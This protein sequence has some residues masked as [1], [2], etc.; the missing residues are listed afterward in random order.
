[1]AGNVLSN[2]YPPII[3]SYMPAFLRTQGCR[4]YFSISNFNSYNDIRSNAQ[5]TVKNQNSNAS[6]LK[7]SEY[8]NG[9]KICNVIEDTE[10]EDDYKYYI[11]L[12][13]TD[14]EKGFELNQYYKVQI[15]FTDAALSKPDKSIEGQWLA[16]N[17]AYFSE[18]STI[19]LI[20]GISKPTVTI[21][22]FEK[23]SDDI[24][25]AITTN[26]VDF[27][28]SV[29]F[30]DPGEEETLRSYRIKLY[31]EKD[32]LLTDSGDIYSSSYNSI[33]QI[34]YTFEYE[35]V[36]GNSYQIELEI[37]TYNLYTELYRYDFNVI[38]SG[39][40]KL[41]ADISVTPDEEG[42]YNI[43]KLIGKTSDIFT[44]NITIRRTSSKSNFLLWEDIHTEAISEGKPLDYT[45]YDFSIES[46]VWYKYCAQKRNNLGH[47][48]VALQY[49]AAVMCMFE[50]IFLVGDNKQLRI[51]YN[52]QVS[53]YKRTVIDAKTDT[54]G[55][56]FPFIKRN[57]YV[58][59]RQFPISGMIT[60]F[61]DY[62]DIFTSREELFGDKSIELYDAYN[63][64]N[65]I[66]SYNDFVHEREFREKVMDFLYADKV[67]LF[68]SLSEGNILIRLMD[69]NLTPET[70]LGRQIYS[71]SATAC[72]VDTCT[73]KNLDKYYIQSLGDYSHLITYSNHI[74]DK[75]DG[76]FSAGESNDLITVL[77]QKKYNEIVP[78]G[79][80]SVIKYL[81]YL[82]IEFKMPPYLIKEDGGNLRKLEATEEPD[83]TTVLG[84]IA[85]INNI[86][87]LINSEGIYELKG[88]EIK[89]NSLYFPID[90]IATVD[91][92]VLIS[93]T[94][95]T[96]KLAK[97]IY[98][99]QRIGQIGGSF[100]YKD[101]VFQ[102]IWNKYRLEYKAYY[103][104]LISINSVKIEAN[105]GTVVWIK[106]SNNTDLER[107][108]INENNSLQIYDDNSVIEGLYFCG[109]HL[110]PANDL[111]KQGESLPENK[112]IE[113]GI[114][115]IDSSFIENPIQNG[116]YTFSNQPLGLIGEEI[117]TDSAEIEDDEI[118]STT[119]SLYEQLLETIT[120]NATRYIYYKDKWRIFTGDNDVLCSVDAIVDYFCEIMKGVY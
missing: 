23:A 41:D 70:T 35:L 108:V 44:G 7:K 86:P 27:I 118:K 72:E 62:N 83:A 91:Y 15:R 107:Y 5:V 2:L 106:E 117:P 49:P 24:S 92:N 20:K 81:D 29:S 22:N 47:R 37:T 95:D 67:R 55:S 109:Y 111:D 57:G 34:N 77:L 39:S 114:E 82:R 61:D 85:Y 46:G 89:V 54:I 99:T 60:L 31:N 4:I 93:E 56:Q 65:R 110:E 40:D 50:D 25:I 98:Y 12:D 36:D 119:D 103:Q 42:G 28:G 3:E 51:K 38:Q 97:L 1:M 94:E 63:W 26:T 68:R 80:I 30:E 9:I 112:F 66:N 8:P 71:F 6:V 78:N 32:T 11:Q 96:S 116:V 100:D 102:R 113:T 69:I 48:G 14:L 16:A 64:E 17:T 120:E 52:P 43:I 33:N 73:I 19:C 58:N 84:Y 45:W 79:Y 53:S 105:P 75:L 59:Y 76:T 115:N 13:P 90:T 104:K 74:L 10:I 87:V 18:W 101:S 88:K 21:H